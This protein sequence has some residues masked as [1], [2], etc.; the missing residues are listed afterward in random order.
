MPSPPSE[1]SIQRDHLE[2]MPQ[3]SAIPMSDSSTASWLLLAACVGLLFQCNRKLRNWINTALS[4]VIHQYLIRR[5]PIYHTEDK[6]QQIPTCPYQFPN[7]QGDIGKFLQGMENSEKWM[8]QNGSIY[9]I[10]SGTRQEV[11]LTRPEHLQLVF[12]D[13]DKHL[14]AVNNNS[15][16]LMGQLLGRCV[17][18]ISGQEWKTVRQGVEAPFLR[19]NAAGYVP[20]VEKHI[21]DHFDHLWK[22][23][24][25]KE[26]LLDPA[27]DL[28]LLPFWVVA[29]IFYGE[30]SPEMRSELRDLVPLREKLFKDVI[31]GGIARFS[32]SR[33]LPTK[34]NRALHQFQRQWKGFNNRAYHSA[35]VSST[36]API[37]HMYG[38]IQNGTMTADQVLQTIDESLYAN[39]DVT[40]GGISWNLVFLAA[41]PV[42]QDRLRS[43][44][45]ARSNSEDFKQYVTDGS[46]LLAACITESSRLK[47]LAAFSV[48]QAAP[49]ARVV[50]GFLIPAGTD[51]IVD[52]LSLNIRNDFW[53]PDSTQYKPERFLAVGRVG[54]R[55][56]LWRFGFGPRQCMGKYIADIIIRALLVHLVNNY[57]LAILDP[58]ADWLRNSEMWINHPDMKIACTPQQT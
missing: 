13:S 37:V 28:R 42:Y 6:E 12:K 31:R 27:K 9:R 8:K 25:L 38:L 52:S 11:V 46:T 51:F 10:W 36:N 50:D 34:T 26:G 22:E 47:P 53:G 30:L 57:D 56:H 49:T 43:E 45:Q 33:Y 3:S 14:K 4:A 2:K 1:L 35:V 7:G 29:E 18:L 55:Y 23:S 40:T 15:G 19:K 20:L 16:Y 21:R 24:N 58:S 48:P 17:G 41:N 44:Y 5:F 54:L 39:L 32:F